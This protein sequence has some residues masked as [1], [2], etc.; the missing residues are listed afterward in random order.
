MSAG[1]DG[2]IWGATFE[3]RYAH[4]E[5]LSSWTGRDKLTIDKVFDNPKILKGVSKD[6]VQRQLGFQERQLDINML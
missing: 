1:R 6:A 3:F 4:K 5:G 2:A